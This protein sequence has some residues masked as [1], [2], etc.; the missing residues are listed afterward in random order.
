MPECG[1]KAT[2]TQVIRLKKLLD[3]GRK[4]K[5][6]IIAKQFGVSEMRSIASG[7]ARTGRMWMYPT[8]RAG[9]KACNADPGRMPV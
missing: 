6:R 8:L 2:S 5:L 4:T 9:L 3:P 7:L 1:Q